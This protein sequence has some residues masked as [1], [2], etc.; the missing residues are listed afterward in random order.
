MRFPFIGL[1]GGGTRDKNKKTWAAP[2]G[3]RPKQSLREKEKNR[4]A[5]PAAH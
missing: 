5:A 4:Y 1:Q 2:K 3:L